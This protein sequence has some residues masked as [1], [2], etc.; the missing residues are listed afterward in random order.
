M[1]EAAI[2]Q[3]IKQALLR[4]KDK[5]NTKSKAVE[6]RKQSNF[7]PKSTVDPKKKSQ[8]VIIPI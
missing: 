4:E 8:T 2:I 3:K 1:D 7:T 5:P 6:G